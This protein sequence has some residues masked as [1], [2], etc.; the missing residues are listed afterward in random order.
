[1]LGNKDP[2]QQSG[3]SGQLELFN[4][5]S[6]LANGYS[7][8]DVINAS[9]NMIINALRQACATRA[10]AEIAFDEIF[11]Q[12]KTLLMNH[13]ESTGRKKGIFA[14]DQTISVPHFDARTYK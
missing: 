4:R 6:Q 14:Y 13:Y 7:A 2:I 8:N 5:Y 10:K 12:A 3:P 1:M 9:M 11:G